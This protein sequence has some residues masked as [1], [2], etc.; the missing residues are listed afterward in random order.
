MKATHEE[1][2]IPT[3]WQRRDIRIQFAAHESIV[4][5]DARLKS[6]DSAASLIATGEQQISIGTKTYKT[7]IM[8]SENLSALFLRTESGSLDT[9]HKSKEVGTELFLSKLSQQI[10]FLFTFTR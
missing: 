1:K 4:I 5:D 2:F 7:I 10:Y 8:Q 6:G 9:I 3:G